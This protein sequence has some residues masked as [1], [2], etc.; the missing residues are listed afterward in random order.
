MKLAKEMDGD[1]MMVGGFLGVKLSKIKQ[2][3]TEYKTQP[4]YAAWNMLVGWRDSTEGS[5][6]HKIQALK[7]ALVDVD[8]QDIADML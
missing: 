3:E 7:G 4:K 1:W 2:L 8:R 6:R 5:V